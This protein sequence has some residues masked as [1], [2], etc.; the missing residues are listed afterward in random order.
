M[1]RRRDEHPTTIYTRCEGCGKIQRPTPGGEL[2]E[3]WI[4]LDPGAQ[5]NAGRAV[6]SPA[7]AE[8][9]DRTA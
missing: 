4:A 7:C 6:C 8:K 5:S 2:P 9:L 3:G 1:T